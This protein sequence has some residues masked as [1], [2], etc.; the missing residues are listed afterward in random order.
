MVDRV[1]LF[2]ILRK[3]EYAA[4]YLGLLI[5]PWPWTAYFVPKLMG[6]FCVLWLL[7]P[8]WKNKIKQGLNSSLS[9]ICLGFFLVNLSIGLFSLPNPHLGP[10]LDYLRWLAFLPVCIYGAGYNTEQK[11]GLQRAFILS[12]IPMVIFSLKVIFSYLTHPDSLALEYYFG[13]NLL[14]GSTEHRVFLSFHLFGALCLLLFK[15]GI[16]KN[17]K[18]HYS[19]LAVLFLYFLLL[20]SRLFFVVLMVGLCLWF[21]Y[22]KTIPKKIKWS[23]TGLTALAIALFFSLNPNWIKTIRSIQTGEIIRNESGKIDRNDGISTRKVLW[24]AGKEMAENHL[25]SP[26]GPGKSDERFKAYLIN[27]GAHELAEENFYT[28]NQYFDTATELGVAGLALL[29]ALLSWPFVR[30]YQLKR[31]ELWALGFSFVLFG[32]SESFL[33]EH[34]HNEI[35][36]C[37]LIFT[38][39]E[40]SNESL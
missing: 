36:Y 7:D 9:I 4:L 20:A 3:A 14:Y 21:I 34:Y 1:K 31:P 32:F 35:L 17:T 26:V 33:R 23:A 11:A 15:Q 19:V 18:I 6:T 16:I 5:Y 37:I 24:I 29:V 40:S 8:D 2:E 10:T 27:A 39:T 38:L 30:G 22:E 13:Q 25:L 12:F 28:H